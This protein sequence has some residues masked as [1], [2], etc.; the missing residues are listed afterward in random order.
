MYVLQPELLVG[1]IVFAFCFSF[2][3]YIFFFFLL[4]FF[5]GGC[6]F[7]KTFLVSLCC[8]FFF[9][10]WF[11]F[12]FFFLVCLFFLVGVIDFWRGILPVFFSIFACFGGS[13]EIKGFLLVFFCFLFAF[14][15]TFFRS[16]HFIFK[17]IM[18]IFEKG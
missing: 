11:F 15:F 7:F 17:I 1:I 2:V 14:F 16:I 13:G 5:W 3:S 10:A 6:M 18:R 9:L 12:V 4:V 8:C